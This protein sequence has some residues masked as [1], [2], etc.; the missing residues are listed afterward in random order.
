M[1]GQKRMKAIVFAVLCA[2]F[3]SASAEYIANLAFDISPGM[4]SSNP[5]NLLNLNGKIFFSA[6][7]GA[8]GKE[9]RILNESGTYYLLKDIN[10]GI[11]SSIIGAFQ[12]SSNDVSIIF[13]ASDGQNISFWIT[14]GSSEGTRKIK[15]I[16]D[17]AQ[18]FGLYSIGVYSN[19]IYIS[20]SVG[21]WKT[22][23]TSQNTA[24][25]LPASQFSGRFKV[26][27]EYFVF[28]APDREI[29][30][31]SPVT[32]N[33]ISFNPVVKNDLTSNW[34][35]LG[36]NTQTHIIYSKVDYDI[37]TVDG[38][39]LLD[40]INATSEKILSSVGT[41]LGRTGSSIEL[42]GYIYFCAAPSYASR[43][44]YRTDGTAENTVYIGSETSCRHLSL[45]KDEHNVYTL[46]GAGNNL[47]VNKI[48]NST[49]TTIIQLNYSGYPYDAGEIYVHGKNLLFS[50]SDADNVDGAWHLNLE[51]REIT[52]LSD[53]RASGFI[54]LGDKYYYVN[55]DVDA[56]REIWHIKENTMIMGEERF[57]DYSLPPSG[58][59]KG[60][61]V[62]THG[63]NSD[64][65]VW[66]QDMA[67]DI[68][69]QEISGIWINQSKWKNQINYAC[70]SEK[71][72]I[73]LVDWRQKASTPFPVEAWNRATNP[74]RFTGKPVVHLGI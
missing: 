67:K 48:L 62:I 61:I 13:I 51:T 37:S 73:L 49:I 55:T 24:L 33:V 39:V 41:H 40:V 9:P 23:G 12:R 74:G 8:T 1:E 34:A 72:D 59:G 2:L 36:A 17:T 6:D 10:P 27:G 64:V 60:V 32:N 38:F 21:L 53:G 52:R 57:Y 25:V 54:S 7:D 45:T 68:C 22:D 18:Y 15:D 3:S 35:S 19:Y 56:G 20:T 66:A 11:E 47:T 4:S 30:R 46:S 16:T 65:E 71:W 58:E 5:G 69:E 43:G 31:F 63:W 29:K 26:V 50:A 70:W 44:W 28:E 42:N 14:D